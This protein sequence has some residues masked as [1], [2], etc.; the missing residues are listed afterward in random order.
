MFLPLLQKAA[1]TTDEDDDMSCRRSAI[2]NMSTVLA[3]VKKCPETFQMAQMYPYRT[4]KAALNMLTC[5]QAEDFKHQGILVTAI[6][7]GWVRTEMGG[8]QA[9]LIPQDSVAGMLRVMST[10]SNKHSGLLLDWE[11][12]TIPW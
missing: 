12:N 7:P 5:C 11:G 8:Q 6:H 10:L 2:I 4:S 3:S 9:P 1:N